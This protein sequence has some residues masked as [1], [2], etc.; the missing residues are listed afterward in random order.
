MIEQ[1][2]DE[3]WAGHTVQ[4]ESVYFGMESIRNHDWNDYLMMCQTLISGGNRHVGHTGSLHTIARLVNDKSQLQDYLDKCADSPFWTS[5]DSEFKHVCETLEHVSVSTLT[6]LATIPSAINGV[7][8]DHQTH[9]V[10]ASKVP[11]AG[12]FR[13]DKSQRGL[14]GFVRSYGN[15][16]MTCGCKIDGDRVENR[17]I[18]R[19]PLS[20]LEKT[21]TH[22]SMKLHQF[23]CQVVLQHFPQIKVFRVRPLE[24]M[25]KLFLKHF[26][27][28]L[29][30]EFYEDKE[31]LVPILEFCDK[32]KF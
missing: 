16:I 30:G 21:Y 26:P 25:G 8:L 14:A 29:V 4:G 3:V 15:I 28:A 22:I 6:Q 10:Y 19:N 27:E 18:F 20:I 9:F 13:F 23:V 31:L 24:H 2:K 7:N 5:S 17:G 32:D 12:R 11:I 1:L